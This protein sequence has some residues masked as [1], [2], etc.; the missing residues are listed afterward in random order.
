MEKRIIGRGLLAGALAGVLAFVFARIFVEPMIGRAIDY[1]DGVGAAH[2]AMEVAAGA[3]TA[4]LR[5][6][7]CSPA[8]SRSNIGMG[9]G[10]LAFSVAMG[11]LFA[12]VF[13]WPTAASATSRPALLSV[14]VAG[15]MLV[16]YCGRARPEVPRRTHRRSASTRRSGSARCCTC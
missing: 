14:L 6:V 3:D 11:A 1:E 16:V 7:S 9:L 10:V 13:A 12:V 8:V 5:A 15:G 4:T 2:E